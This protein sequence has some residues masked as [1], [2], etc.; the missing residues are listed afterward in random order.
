MTISAVY[1]IASH[2]RRSE[3]A[4]IISSN[5]MDFK[6]NRALR[7]TPPNLTLSGRRSK[8]IDKKQEIRAGFQT[9][10]TDKAIAFRIVVRG[11]I[12]RS[13][14]A[15]RAIGTIGTAAMVARANFALIAIPRHYRRERVAPRAW[16]R[17]VF[18][19]S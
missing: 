9:A 13:A 10:R 15:P 16:N 19:R 6:R 17:Q 1:R 7:R 14:S 12:V 5:S 2:R 11:Q 3:A 8:P 4:V 18:R